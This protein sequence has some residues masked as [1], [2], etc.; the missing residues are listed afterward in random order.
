MK[1]F[2]DVKKNVP[3]I[4][5]Q[6]TLIF[7]GRHLHLKYSRLKRYE[8]KKGLLEGLWECRAAQARNCCKPVESS[9]KSLPSGFESDPCPREALLFFCKL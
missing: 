6:A 4:L 1:K 5:K 2:Y 8:K 7:L 9:L 3:R